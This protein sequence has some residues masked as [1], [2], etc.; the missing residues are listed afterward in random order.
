V[1][2]DDLWAILQNDGIIILHIQNTH[3][4]TQ[5]NPLQIFYKKVSQFLTCPSCIC[6][7][8]KQTLWTVVSDIPKSHPSCHLLLSHLTLYYEL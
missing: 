3:T 4:H 5:T 1:V 7:Y 2:L 8:S 6:L